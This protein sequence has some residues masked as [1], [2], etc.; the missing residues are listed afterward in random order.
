MISDLYYQCINDE[1]RAKGVRTSRDL[2]E[3]TLEFVKLYTVIEKNVTPITGKPLLVRSTAQFSK[4]VVDKVTSLDGQQ[5]SV[6]FIS[7][8]ESVSSSSNVD[9]NINPSPVPVL[10]MSNTVSNDKLVQLTNWTVPATNKS[11]CQS[12]GWSIE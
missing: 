5:H 4:I 9:T 11:E 2:P 6:M 1:M 3:K 12:K 8:N 7:N 10:K